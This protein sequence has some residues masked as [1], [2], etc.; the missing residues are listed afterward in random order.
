MTHSPK[1]SLKKTNIPWI[2]EIPEDWEVKR[3]KYV[4]NTRVS[5]VDKKSED[6][7]QIRLCNYVDVYKNDYIEDGI[8]FM[9][10]TATA[11]QIKTFKLNEG[12][13]LFTKDSETANDIGVPAYV[14][15][16]NNE[17]IVC[18][19]HL[20]ISS[21]DDSILLGQF[22]FRFFQSKFLQSYFEVNCN[23]VTRYGLD[24]YSIINAPIF[25][26]PLSVQSTIA[27]FLDAKTEKISTLISNKK[28]LIDLLKEQKQSIIH[29]AVTKGIDKNAKMKDSEIPWIW[30]IPEDWEILK[31]KYTGKIINWSTPSSSEK[32][33]WDWDIDWITPT[34]LGNSDDPNL[35]QSGRKITKLW[36]ENCGTTIVPKNSIILSC[37]APIWSLGITTKDMCTNQGCKA[38]IVN[39]RVIYQY[40][41]FHFIAY[42]EYLQSL[43]KW[44]TFQELSTTEFENSYF[45]LPS[46]ITQESIVEYIKKEAFQ[47]D[48]A[49]YKIE[50]EI[51]LIEEY[52]T[53]LIY[54]AVT[55]KL[56]IS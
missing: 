43:W 10:A 37:R 15:I 2:W 45:I 36:L 29:Q 14:K 52:R 47:I 27:H 4:S 53:S 18:G 13:V 40:V 12:D 46:I 11:Q 48:S 56:S 5:N 22:L 24:I 6:D 19:Y 16:Q 28:K 50:Q 44:T 41:Y 26:P 20:G 31:L 51:T 8:D 17:D 30:E 35:Y 3:L 25:I 39:S 1:T 21:P 23:G 32:D 49:I 9:M 7:I 38:F 34:D 54:Q 55:G 33:Y 42:N